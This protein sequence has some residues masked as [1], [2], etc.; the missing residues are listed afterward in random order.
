VHTFA[1][2]L[3]VNHSK[4]YV[5]PVS[6][7][8]SNTIEGNWNGVKMH[9]PSRL[10]TKDKVNLYLTRFMLARNYEC[11]PLIALINYLSYLFLSFIILS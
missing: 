3:M 11:H 1:D 8:H 2:H 9:I 6:G 7:V 10:R 5:D 4:H